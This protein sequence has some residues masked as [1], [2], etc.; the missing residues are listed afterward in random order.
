[1]G[2]QKNWTGPNF[3]NWSSAENWDPAGAPVAGDTVAISG[4]PAV[5]G[6]T[7]DGLSVTFDGTASVGLNVLA[8]VTVGADTVLQTQDDG[9]RAALLLGDPLLSAGTIAASGG[10]FRIGGAT[11]TST[12]TILAAGANGESGA[13]NYD[14]DAIAN[15]GLAVAQSNGVMA[16]LA[17]TLTNTGTAE[18]L[19]GGTW[20]LN[21]GEF[22]NAGT[23]AARGGTLTVNGGTV[24]NDAT[25]DVADAGVATIEAGTLANAAAFSLGANA[26]VTI[27]GGTLANTGTIAASNNALLTLAGG[28]LLNA[29]SALLAEHATLSLAGGTLANAGTLSASDDASL[30]LSGGLLLNQGSI[31]LAGSARLQLLGGT[32][33]NAGTLSLSGRVQVGTLASSIT[34]TGLIA[35][36]RGVVDDDRGD[37]TL[38]NNGTIAI[39]TGHWVEDG[40][41]IGGNGTISLSNGGS[42]TTGSFG[43]QTIDFADA[44]GRVNIWGTTGLGGVIGAMQA[45]D[46]IDV[47][48]LKADAASYVGPD[49]PGG[50]GTLVLTMN[51]TI[52]GTMATAATLDNL[53][54]TLEPD[55]GFG[56]LLLTSNAS[57]TWNGGAGSW[58]DPAQWS[59]GTT[60][61]P[62]DNET[63]Q[64]G[65]VTLTNVDGPL[66]AGTILLGSSIAS[67]MPT[68]VIDN[69]GIG[70]NAVLT[71]SANSPRYGE[72]VIAGTSTLDG[73][74]SNYAQSG[75]LTIDL[76]SDGTLAAGTLTVGGNSAI[77]AGTGSGVAIT[78]AG[79]VVNNG[80]LVANGALNIA[81]GVTIDNDGLI[82]IANGGKVLANGMV[83]G[84]TVMFD[85]PL[86]TLAISDLNAFNAFITD[87]Q[88]GDRLDLTNEIVSSISYVP[89]TYDAQYQYYTSGT[90]TVIGSSGTNTIS[91]L[92]GTN[93][94]L[95]NGY[96]T[97]ASDGANGTNI[98]FV[99]ADPVVVDA[100]I[101]VAAVG[102]ADQLISLRQILIDAFGEVPTNWTSFT[103]SADHPTSG[104]LTAEASPGGEFPAES[105]W[106][107]YMTGPDVDPLW[108][109]NGATVSG[110]TT[111]VPASEIDNVMFQVG[112]A[113]L[114]GAWFQVTVAGSDSDPTEVM[115]YNMW[116]V[117]PAVSGYTAGNTTAPT[118]ADVVA[119]ANTYAQHYYD[120]QNANNCNWIADNVAAG[121][122]ATMPWYNYSTDPSANESGGFWRIQHAGV[123]SSDW[124][125]LVTGGDVVRMGW[126]GLDGGGIGEHTT[127][128]LGPV[129]GDA[130]PVYDNNDFRSGY[131]T[132][133]IGTHE[134]SYWD[135]TLPQSITV[136]A[137]DP[138][139]QYLIEGTTNAESI[140]GSVF[141]NL[142]VPNGGGDTI[143]AGAGLNEIADNTADLNGT[144]ITDFHV[145]DWIDFRD[146]SPNGAN[147]S[148]DPASGALAITSNGVDVANLALPADL[149][150]V[151]LF[152]SDG[153][154]GTQLYL[155]CYAAGTLIATP[156]G[157]RAV[158]GIRAGEHV[159]TASGEAV[160]VAWTGSRRVRCDRHP[161]PRTVW[162]VCIRAGAFGE[163]MPRRDLWLSPNHA[164]FVDGVLIPAKLL[165]NG[166]NVVQVPLAE[167]RYH[168]IELARHDIL[169]A[170]NL[171]AESMLP[172]TDRGCFVE[173]EGA[174]HLHP[175]F[176]ALPDPALGWEGAACAP[177]VVTGPAL[178]AVRRR[179]ADCAPACLEA[180]RAG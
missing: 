33:A 110:S 178:A 121:I 174:L 136:Y 111:I 91:I 12:G 87:F 16:L 68:L 47:E 112:N 92:P 29:G 120:T 97:T 96:F 128:V 180:I 146:L 154:A 143:T 90:L 19:S 55:G 129:E 49:S 86:S 79:T 93:Y 99:Q 82:E 10:L 83:S 77:A 115:Q 105:Y 107:D 60:P 141:N 133:F 2:E 53:S 131:G 59:T 75:E 1:M 166:E 145:G 147:L 172:G 80:L 88:P 71:M 39:A 78:G 35:I 4:I 134:A 108:V 162:P 122:G 168:H 51:G 52:V 148:Y 101:P 21:G 164:V 46:I 132:A 63:I 44:Y 117:D 84:G 36:T 9:T 17:G 25:L 14:A 30:A 118:A 150:G 69:T 66:G 50:Y 167:A 130:L 106:T 54:F 116:S 163:A 109:V 123:G 70:D 3:G 7:L 72:V 5:T 26:A 8:G 42:F 149:P 94:Q 144:D 157:Q 170:E 22:V 126:S 98:T 175:D 61:L 76:A 40:P 65:T 153:G 11:L 48:N 6:D 24:V 20:T 100:S 159:L 41:P 81:T 31:V 28:T 15:A 156:Q 135:A 58:Y 165:V 138:N 57:L 152:G 125:T 32:L 124:S 151:F 127:T 43:D 38:V 13:I 37:L 18:A 27:A 34:N 85:D 158:E 139:G 67:A 95:E 56:V 103:L 104:T 89:G 23:V 74:I 155:A 62:G 73:Q 142:I 137:L 113:I 176:A 179:L 161:E 102:T 173:G 171:P 119:S 64:G 114:P 140:Q 177:L 169:L 160:E 45:G